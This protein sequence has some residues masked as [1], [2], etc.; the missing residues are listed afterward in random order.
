MNTSLNVAAPGET[1]NN[2]VPLAFL[3]CPPLISGM[4]AER[5]SL[6]LFLEVAAYVVKY[7]ARPRQLKMIAASCRSDSLTSCKAGGNHSLH[8]L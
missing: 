7:S 4:H 3:Y 2:T 8:L 1:F 6:H 5:K